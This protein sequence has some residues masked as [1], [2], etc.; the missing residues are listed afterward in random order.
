MFT[1]TL[2][3]PT[4]LAA[5][6]FGSL[7]CS[8]LQDQGAVSRRDP[9]ALRTAAQAFAQ[10]ERGLQALQAGSRDL[11]QAV[12]RFQTL[13]QRELGTDHSLPA[14][15]ARIVQQPGFTPFFLAPDLIQSYCT[16]I[17]GS[18]QLGH[19][20]LASI[21]L[22][23]SLEAELRQVEQMGLP[24]YRGQSFVYF[25][26]KAAEHKEPLLAGHALERAKQDGLSLT[27]A[28]FQSRLQFLISETYMIQPAIARPLTL[29][30]ETRNA[31]SR[32]ED[33]G[34][35]HRCLLRHVALFYQHGLHEWGDQLISDL[36]VTGDT[37]SLCQAMSLLSKRGRHALIPSLF[38]HILSHAQAD[39]DPVHRSH[40]LR[41]LAANLPP[42]GL[43][44]LG[45]QLIDEL[46]NAIAQQPS[47]AS[48]N[49]TLSFIAEATLNW[50]L[51]LMHLNW[52]TSS[53]DIASRISDASDRAMLLTKL[54]RTLADAGAPESAAHVNQLVREAIEAD[55]TSGF[56]F[57]LKQTAAHLQA[58]L[59]VGQDPASLFDRS[60]ASELV[61]G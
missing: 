56:A 9:Q 1:S 17:L 6:S 61:S 32:I 18:L 51:R 23:P 4:A 30:T 52:L 29:L 22:D 24:E 55:P 59:H 10:P 60:H 49:T 16:E 27:D 34:T 31:L 8:V 35:R 47:E 28:S 21:D 39:T 14:G 25:A 53:L 50:Y 41:T 2:L 33:S 58:N 5:T 36:H 20:G 3:T 44:P 13:L 19:P 11:S 15:L 42:A 26:R 48:H 38:R 37:A 7:V 54:A 12:W 45:P 46:V 57:A 43:G 40:R